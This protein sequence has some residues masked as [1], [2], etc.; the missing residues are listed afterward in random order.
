MDKLWK[1]HRK[2]VLKKRVHPVEGYSRC[3]CVCSETCIVWH[4]H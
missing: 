4:C 2:S 1:S 3:T